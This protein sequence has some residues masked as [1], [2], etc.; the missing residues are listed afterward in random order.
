MKIIFTFPGQGSQ[1]PNML[2][3]LPDYPV[4]QQFI[5]RASDALSEDVLTLDSQQALQNTRAV[6]LCILISGIVHAHLLKQAG[7][8]ADFTSGL[9]I[10]A[11]P[12]AVFAGA[13]NFED[14]VRLVSL[15]GELMQHA[16]PHGYGLTSIQGLYQRQ[17]EALVAQVHRDN[18]P[19]YIANFNDED[20]FVIAGSEAA[21]QQIAQL[22]GQLGARKSTRLAV[23]VPSH[24]AL[25]QVASEQ[26]AQAMRQV[27]FQRPTLGYLSGNSA[28]MVNDPAKIATDLANNMS[29][30]VHW[31]DAMISAYERGVRLAIEIPPGAVL[32]G[33]TKKMMPQG[34]AVS[35]CQTGLAATVALS[36]TLTQ[37]P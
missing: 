34:E 21:M 17:I 13:L 6:Q 32:T 35:V 19:A 15:R 33:L 27:T 1:Q 8:Q 30:A 25:L 9:S 37:L 12:A 24:C 31:H 14:A 16:Y 5:Q 2:H 29:H 20:Q 22:A 4:T 3:Q 7:I 10:G 11:F 36:R 23:S 28:R 26:L 18:N